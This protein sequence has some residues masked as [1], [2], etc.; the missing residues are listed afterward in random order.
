MLLKRFVGVALLVS[1][2]IIMA[3]WYFIPR[4][5]D[6]E[7]ADP[8]P[9]KQPPLVKVV[10]VRATAIAS[11]LDLTGEVVASNSTI[12]STMKEGR[13][14]FCSWR[15]GDT[16]ESGE[17]LVLIDREVYQKEVQAAQAALDLAQAKL[18]D[19][20]AGTRPEEIRNAEAILSRYQATLN[21]ARQSFER[22]SE[23]FG[24]G[25]VTQEELG[26]A[27]E[28]VE[29]AEAEMSA[30][31]ETLS[32]LKTGATTTELAVPKATVSEA[33]ARLSLAKAHL[34]E[35]VITA[36]FGGTISRVYVR[37]GDVAS[38][39]EPLIEMFAPDSLVIR[40]AVPEAQAFAVH[41]GMS[42]SIS[43]DAA[44]DRVLSAEVARIYPELD[45]IMRTRTIE[46]AL[47]DPAELAPH[48][49][50]RLTLNTAQAN[51]ALVVP[52]EAVLVTPT[53]KRQLFVIEDGKAVLRPIIIGIEDGINVQIV[54]GVA[55]GEK[56][57]VAGNEKLKQD[58]V[59]RIAPEQ[60]KAQERGGQ[61]G[62]PGSESGTQL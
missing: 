53:G 55:A 57:A 7:S 42:L 23:L 60:G 35:C 26:K 38:Q 14:E 49:F 4:Q 59:V 32:R 21:E 52:A 47:A 56:V 8:N 44:P 41:T 54:S 11:T 10:P 5:T 6:T 45:P 18:E 48:M 36:P 19:L 27:Q 22:L 40:F 30:A 13:I 20:M 1:A 33:A 15:E 12:I 39:R 34:A 62:Q 37:P 25:Y 51:D 9:Q 43:L 28:R 31:S 46:V 58:M 61:G 3:I 16:A 17:T 29:V 24:K 50:A 2:V